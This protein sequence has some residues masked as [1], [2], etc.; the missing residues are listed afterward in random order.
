MKSKKIIAVV[1]AAVVLVIGLAAAGIFL[2]DKYA[3]GRDKALA[4]AMSDANCSEALAESYSS[5]VTLKEGIVVYKV[6]F[7][8]DGFAYEYVISSVTDKIISKEKSLKAVDLPSETELS[9]NTNEPITV[10]QKAEITANIP[11][12][13]S[14]QESVTQS[15]MT[16]QKSTTVESQTISQEE[17]PTSEL[18]QTTGQSGNTYIGIDKAKEIALRYVGIDASKVIF[19]KAKLDKEH[20]IRVYKIEFETA[21]TEYEF[22]IHAISGDILEFSKEAVDD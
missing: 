16:T 11:S 10:T 12:T 17:T 22:E 18:K 15:D 20:G 3:D 6:D 21:L 4:L 13:E 5:A 1:L 2:T 8:F 9:A 19:T 7:S 14:T